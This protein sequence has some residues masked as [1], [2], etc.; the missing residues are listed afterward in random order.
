MCPVLTIN[1]NDIRIRLQNPTNHTEPKEHRALRLDGGFFGGL[2]R[3]LRG[4][5]IAP[6]PAPPLLV[7][8]HSFLLPRWAGWSFLGLVRAGVCAY[9]V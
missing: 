2:C 7:C 3:G 4:A 6:P 1:R 5:V 8:F 9:R